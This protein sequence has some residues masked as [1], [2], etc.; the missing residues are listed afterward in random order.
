MEGAV[1]FVV[2][3]EQRGNDLQV[4]LYINAVEQVS[5]H[6]FH[7]ELVMETRYKGIRKT[8]Y[9]NAEPNKHTQAQASTQKH[10]DALTVKYLYT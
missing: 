9:V 4:I 1:A 8:N 3:L 5:L 7:V 2:F 10:V 6:G